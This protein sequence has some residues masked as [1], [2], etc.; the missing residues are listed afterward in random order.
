[1]GLLPDSLPGYIPTAHKGL[2]YQ[3]ML[4]SP[5]IKALFVMGANPLR[6]VSQLPPNLELL[7]V[8]DITLTEVAR[9]ADIVL[10]AVTFA[11]KDGSMT[12][13]D[14][15]VQKI[16]HALRPLQGAKADWE[17]LTLLANQLGHRWSYDSPQD[18]LL[19]IA[20]ANP[21]YSG[22]T[23]EDLGAQG[24]RTQEEEVAHA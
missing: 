16:L 1:M 23:W 2:N 8:Q 13:I 17:I 20:A 24:V 21:F 6:H 22:L 5:D 14:H 15:H 10:P 7:V 9:Q 3:A 12:N 18:V 4:S 19:E 11:E